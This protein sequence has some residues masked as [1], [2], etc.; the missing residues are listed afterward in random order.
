MFAALPSAGRITTAHTTTCAALCRQWA[1]YVAKA[2]CLRKVFVSVKGIYYQAEIMGEAVTW[3]VPHSFT[4]S[5]PREVD[6]RVMLTFLEF[7]E[8][9]MRFTLFKL[10]HM[11]GLAYPPVVDPVLDAAGGCLLAVQDASAAELPAPTT[12]PKSKKTKVDEKLQAKVHE[13]LEEMPAEEDEDEVELGD[14]LVGPLSSAFSSVPAHSDNDQERSAIAAAI[15]KSASM[16]NLFEGLIFFLNREVPRAC[17]QVCILALGGLVGWQGA[18]SPLDINDPRITHHVVDRPVQSQ[19]GKSREYIQP[20]WVFDSINAQMRLPVRPYA[21]GATLPP[22]LSPFVDDEK[23]GYMPQYRE[24]IHRLQGKAVPSKQDEKEKEA[25]TEDEDDDEEED[26]EVENEEDDEEDEEEAE[27]EEDESESEEELDEVPASK[28]AKAVDS[29]KGPKAVVFQNKQTKVSEVS[30]LEMR[31]TVIR[32]L[33]P[34]GGVCAVREG[35]GPEM[36]EEFV[37]KG[38]TD[39]NDVVWGRAPQGTLAP[40]MDKNVRG[41]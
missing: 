41:C 6:F 26:E 40:S 18:G 29:K 24:E 15:D 35:K 20:Q 17:L 33:Y 10:Y 13:A 14:A 3:L 27:D 32:L 9:F 12:V 38:I 16:A 2:R 28:Q 39:Q 25:E 30:R 21:P 31:W 23:E 7:Y 37:L 34:C 22:H 19:G 11:Q 5:M 36:R 8:V 1:F 4:Q